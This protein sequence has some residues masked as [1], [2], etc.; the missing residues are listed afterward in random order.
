MLHAISDHGLRTT[1]LEN[2]ECFSMNIGTYC[3]V[4]ILDRPINIQVG[5]LGLGAFPQGYYVYVGSALNGLKAR[6]TRHLAQ[7]KNKHWHIDYLLEY[8]GVIGTRQICSSEKREC[9]LSKEVESICQGIP[10]KG[11]G[12][13]DCP[14][15]S[16][17]Y[18]FSQNPLS[19]PRFEKIWD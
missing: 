14:C 7:Q 2:V 3:L 11:F 8:A 13:S 12:S 18:F 19:N 1:D 10:M 6:V 5:K 17:L 15:Q 9:S 4:M 16:H